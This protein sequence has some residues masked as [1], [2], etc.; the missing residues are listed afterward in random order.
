[1]S[2]RRLACLPCRTLEPVAAAAPF[3]RADLDRL[4]LRGLQFG[5]RDSRH[6]SC[7]NTDLTGLVSGEEMTSRS[8]GGGWS[9]WAPSGSRRPAG[10]TC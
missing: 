10:P 3:D 2:L 7:L 8:T 1:M 6:A 9:S 5:C 4:G